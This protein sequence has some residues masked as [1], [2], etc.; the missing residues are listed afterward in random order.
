MRKK[1]LPPVLVILLILG[2]VLVGATS[3]NRDDEKN[4][5]IILNCDDCV[6]TDQLLT[7]RGFFYIVE[8]SWCMCGEVA[9]LDYYG[10][11]VC[12]LSGLDM[13][14]LLQYMGNYVEVTGYLVDCPEGGCYVLDV[15]SVTILPL[16]GDI[17]GD[18]YVDM[19]IDIADAVYLINYLFRG[20]PEPVP[21]LCVGDVNADGIV[22]VGDVVYLISYLFRG[23]APPQD[24]CCES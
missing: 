9:Y 21:E 19:T 16:C 20:G 10:C 17:N 7:E 11:L 23:G 2:G 18:T 1:I 24:T 12:Y 13:G 4:E 3:M 6:P 14:E 5:N 8:L 22:N 15:E